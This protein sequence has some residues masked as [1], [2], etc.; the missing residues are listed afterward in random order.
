MPFSI[1]KV[2]TKVRDLDPKKNINGEFENI[3]GRGKYE[4]GWGEQD[5]VRQIAEDQAINPEVVIHPK[6]NEFGILG[7][8]YFRHTDIL[9]AIIIYNDVKQR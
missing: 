5:V 8:G 1:P 3:V 6:S 4:G 2:F 7:N 9:N